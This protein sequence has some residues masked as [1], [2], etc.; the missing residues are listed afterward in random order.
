MSNVN[1]ILSLMFEARSSRMSDTAAK[2][3]LRAC[4]SLGLTAEETISVFSSL[5]YCDM[6][7]KPFNARFK[8]IW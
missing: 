7:G 2:R 6:D 4:K 8:R 5:D 1:A 3:I